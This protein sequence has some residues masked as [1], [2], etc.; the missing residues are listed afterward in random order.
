MM[1]HTAG[2]A[3]VSHLQC[4]EQLTGPVEVKDPAAL[5][6]PH[7]PGYLVSLMTP[8]LRLLIQVPWG[9]ERGPGNMEGQVHSTE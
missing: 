8:T 9:L 3:P 7:Q 1:S 5:P 2:Q 6:Q 4:P